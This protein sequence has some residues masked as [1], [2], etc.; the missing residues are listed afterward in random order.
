M[1]RIIPSL[2]IMNEALVKTRQFGDFDYVGDPANSVR[3]FNEIFVDELVLLDISHSKGFKNNYSYLE[4]VVSEAFV[5][6]SFGGGI[7][8]LEIAEII[9]KKGIE[10]LII[11]SQSFNYPFLSDLIKKYGSQAIVV[12]IDYRIIK[13][14]PV[15]FRNS[16]SI[17]HQIDF[18]EHIQSM[19]ELG[20]GELIINAIDRDGM[21][22]GYDFKVLNHTKSYFSG[23]IIAS[24]GCSS[25]EDILNARHIGIDCAVGSM[26]VYQKKDN[27]VL[28]SYPQALRE[29]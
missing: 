26:F 6:I 12:S 10:K 5:P 19:D 4:D 27:G 7:N 20:V 24:G 13:G 28:I 21:W 23:P 16:G 14:E 22:S 8:S 9:F 29:T 17:R 3:I 11:N 2:L 18:L 15:V 1:S 25:S